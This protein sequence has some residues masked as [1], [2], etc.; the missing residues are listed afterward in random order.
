[1]KLTK[2]DYMKLGLERC[3]ELLVE[4]EEEKYPTSI[5]SWV[6]PYT[7]LT[8]HTWQYGCFNCEH[9]PSTS[10]KFTTTGTNTSKED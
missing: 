7:G 9:C 5:T 6:C 10:I 8:C 4:K 1:M 3:A 2:E